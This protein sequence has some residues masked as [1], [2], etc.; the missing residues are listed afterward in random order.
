MSSS[1]H[2]GD[3]KPQN[4]THVDTLSSRRHSRSIGSGFREACRRESKVGITRSGKSRSG[5]DSSNRKSD[6]GSGDFFSFSCVFYLRFFLSPCGKFTDP[7]L[8]S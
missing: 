8:T 3:W 6:Q 4:C 7:A 5:E 1:V 2:A